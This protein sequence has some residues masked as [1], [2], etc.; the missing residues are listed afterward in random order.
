M[1]TRD[2]WIRV[3]FRCNY[4]GAD[5]AYPPKKNRWIKRS[6]AADYLKEHLMMCPGCVDLMLP[7]HIEIIDSETDELIRHS[8][9]FRVVKE[10]V[11]PR[12]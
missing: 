1:T 10:A 3:V 9:H 4:C 11:K 12:K 8:D 6:Q 5:H 2:E 7:P